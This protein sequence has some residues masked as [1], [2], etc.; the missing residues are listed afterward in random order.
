MRLKAPTHRLGRWVGERHKAVFPPIWKHSSLDSYTLAIHAERFVELRTLT[1]S[2]VDL[3]GIVITAERE[4]VRLDRK[5]E[6]TRQ[7]DLGIRGQN[8]L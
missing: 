5:R 6:F 2:A 4:Q 1:D 3:V 7:C 8:G